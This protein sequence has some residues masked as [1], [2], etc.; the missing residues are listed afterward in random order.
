MVD[1]KVYS[2]YYESA[3]R[4]ECEKL[5]PKK[6]SESESTNPIIT[7]HADGRKLISG[8]L[9]DRKSPEIFWEETMNRA[10]ACEFLNS[11]TKEEM[12][13]EDETANDDEMKMKKI[14][15]K[16]KGAEGF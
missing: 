8:T 7:Y 13:A 6:T 9:E 12:E 10:V 15:K 1:P 11:V 14:M 3:D 2:D 4:A 5:F 16:N